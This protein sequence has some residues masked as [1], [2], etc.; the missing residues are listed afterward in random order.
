MVYLNVQEDETLEDDE[1]DY[2]FGV[3]AKTM[4]PVL[5]NNFEVI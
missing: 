2:S 1:L 3:N 4:R 5:D